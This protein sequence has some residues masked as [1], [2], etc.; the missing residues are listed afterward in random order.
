M[1]LPGI[2]PEIRAGNFGISNRISPPKLLHRPS[3]FN[4]GDPRIEKDSTIHMRHSR[5]LP[6]SN[7]RIPIPH[8][9]FPPLPYLQTDPR[10]ANKMLRASKILDLPV[11][12]TTQNVPPIRVELISSPGLSEK[13]SQSSIYRM[14]K[15]PFLIKLYFPCV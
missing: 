8:K 14:P 5:T 11:Y 9:V 13:Q 6:R 2:F 4:H 12:A 7:P 15:I 3:T 1:G 10:T